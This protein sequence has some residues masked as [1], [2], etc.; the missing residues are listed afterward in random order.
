MAGPNNNQS[1]QTPADVEIKPR[2][3]KLNFTDDIPRHWNNNDA[4]KTHFLNSFS[5]TLPIFEKVVISVIQQNRSRIT[6]PV[7]KKEMQDFCVQESSHA[8]EH[9][10]YNQLLI[11]QGYVGIARIESIQNNVLNIILKNTSYNFQLAIV[12]AFEHITSFMGRDF[13]SHPERWSQNSH[14]TMVGVWHWHA[15]EELEHKAFCF[16][17]YQHVCGKWWLRSLALPLINI[18]TLALLTTLHFYMLKVDGLLFRR[19]TWTNYL[20]LMYGANGVMRGLAKEYLKYFRFDFH[21]WS[22][23]DSHLIDLC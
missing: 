14:P 17:V 2:K 8:Q 15:I 7:L 19:S 11:K 13:L 5:S 4:V 21:P 23:N 9:R 6:D 3:I 1:R 12:A 20:Q 22:E 16:D 18:P 10:K